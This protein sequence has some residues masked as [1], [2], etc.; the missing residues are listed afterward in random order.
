MHIIKYIR[1]RCARFIS[2]IIQTRAWVHLFRTGVSYR[3]VAS[4]L[5]VHF[6]N[7]RTLARSLA[8]SLATSGSYLFTCSFSNFARSGAYYFRAE[9]E[10]TEP[11]CAIKIVPPSSCLLSSPST[12]VVVL[13][14][15]AKQF[16]W[17]NSW[18]RLTSSFLFSSRDRRCLLTRYW[19]RYNFDEPKVINA[20]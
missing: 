16:T 20:E 3:A 8:R 17:V 12:V 15:R 14:A 19:Y 18:S 4:R 6:Y 1:K 5:P 11:R 2:N 13:G 10:M 9:K 7:A